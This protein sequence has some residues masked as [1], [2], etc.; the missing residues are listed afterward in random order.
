MTRRSVLELTR[1]WQDF[2]AGGDD[3]G[4]GLE[5]SERRLSMAEVVRASEQGR[6]RRI[7]WSPGGA[8]GICLLPMLT[9][10]FKSYIR[11]SG[12]V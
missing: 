6:V 8:V 2:E 12:T 3:R 11:R 9:D 4:G 10:F 5:V 7:N 1:E